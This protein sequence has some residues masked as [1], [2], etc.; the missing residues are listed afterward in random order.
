LLRGRRSGWSRQIGKRGIRKQEGS[1]ILGK[2]TVAGRLGNVFK[3]HSKAQRVSRN[4]MTAFISKR[5]K[6][7]SLG[8]QPK[9][10]SSAI[11]R[12]ETRPRR[13]NTQTGGEGE[14]GSIQQTKV[15]AVAVLGEGR[16]HPLKVLI[17]LKEGRAVP[18]VGPSSKF[19]IWIRGKKPDGP[20][21]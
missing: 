12:G 21:H 16:D 17:H 2:T 18:L 9:R 5:E 20:P 7:W 4:G 14:F 19:E 13:G 6:K 15:R 10:S 3:N 8:T 1:S 11:G